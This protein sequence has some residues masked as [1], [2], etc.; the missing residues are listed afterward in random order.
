MNPEG[1]GLTP[2]Q[3]AEKL[4]LEGFQQAPKSVCDGTVLC[5]FKEKPK[6]KP[7]SLFFFPQQ[8]KALGLIGPGS[9]VRGGPD[10]RYHASSK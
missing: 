9:G 5:G 7:L 2:G 6:G 3:L 8:L 10:V 4:K 1:M